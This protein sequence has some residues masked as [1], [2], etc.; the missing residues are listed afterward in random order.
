ML[1]PAREQADTRD[2]RD[3][4]AERQGATQRG[5][6]TCRAAARRAAQAPHRAVLHLSP[7]RLHP[8][9]CRCRRVAAR[10]V[11]QVLHRVALRQ[12]LHLLH[13]AEVAETQYSH[14]EVSPLSV[15]TQVKVDQTQLGHLLVAAE[16]EAAV[17]QTTKPAHLLQA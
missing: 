7:L 13:L 1:P 2:T 15:S 14:L 16:E 6:D 3:R 8:P 17:V 12:L 11:A 4:G 5:R 9:R 10:R